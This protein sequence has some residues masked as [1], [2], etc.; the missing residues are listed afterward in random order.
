ME[1]E[2]ELYVKSYLCVPLGVSMICISTTS[3]CVCVFV[4]GFILTATHY[5][6]RFSAQRCSEVG[7]RS[8]PHTLTLGTAYP[9]LAYHY[10]A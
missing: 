3:M 7:E 8:D 2:L 9:F 10:S 6:L 5:S 4:C 1:Y